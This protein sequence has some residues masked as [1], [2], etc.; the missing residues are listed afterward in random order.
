[1]NG[2]GTIPIIVADPAALF[3]E[4]SLMMSKRKK[5]KQASQAL[6]EEF[7]ES[8]SDL[9]WEASMQKRALPWWKIF[10]IIPEEVTD[11]MEADIKKMA[12]DLD[13]RLV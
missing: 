12:D 13:V 5:S 6:P 10:S 11:A 1:M 2:V 9:L 3:Q 4:R 8:V 7:R